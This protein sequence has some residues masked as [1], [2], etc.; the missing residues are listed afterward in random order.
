MENKLTT[1]RHREKPS[2]CAES[3][4]LGSPWGPSTLMRSYRAA[5]LFGGGKPAGLGRFLATVSRY[6]NG[7][8]WWTWRISQ[9][10]S[11][12]STQSVMAETIIR[13]AGYHRPM[14]D[15]VCRKSDRKPLGEMLKHS[16]LL[17]LCM[18][19]PSCP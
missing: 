13:Q 3:L 19:C 1:C 17:L 2:R 4:H 11:S 7:S 6:S 12:H 14:Y 15:A 10:D 5:Q 16:R 8:C 9:C 18:H